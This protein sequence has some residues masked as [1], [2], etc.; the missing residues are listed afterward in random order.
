MLCRRIIPCLDVDHGRTVKGVNFQNLR[1][2]GDPVEHAREY[3]EQGADEVVLLDISASL[4]GRRTLMRVVERVAEV[5]LIPFT[6]GGGIRGLDQVKALLAAGADKISVNSAAVTRPGLIRE[7]SDTCG[8]QS[9][10]L[11]IDARWNASW[12]AW[13]VLTHGGRRSTGIDALAW[14]ENAVS[15]GAGE[16]LLT[17]WDRDGTHAGFDIPLCSAFS[18]RLPVPVIASGGARGPSSFVEAFRKGGADAALAAS[19]FHD[20]L[21]TVEALKRELKREGIEVRL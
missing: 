19:I 12:K 2:V 7:I 16:I 20:G 18:G 10:V 13:E 14:A 17:S 21:W 4:E 11:A 1:A 15:L 3:Q 8:A 6:V 9:C 5:L